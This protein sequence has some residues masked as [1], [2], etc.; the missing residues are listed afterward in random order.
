MDHL[1]DLEAAQVQ[2]AI[3]ASLRPKDDRQDDQTSSDAFLESLVR[4]RKRS[5]APSE[6]YAPSKRSTSSPAFEEHRDAAR[7]SAAYNPSDCLPLDTEED[8]DA[9][10]LSETYNPFESLQLSL[11]VTG[12]QRWQQVALRMASSAQFRQIAPRLAARLHEIAVGAPD[13]VDPS[14]PPSAERWDDGLNLYSTGAFRI[15]C[16]PGRSS[17]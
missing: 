12:Q 17:T 7:L 8:R 11:E 1:A 14:A 16:T 2:A 10:E 6:T 9:A 4:P 3:F 5:R 15:T 13:I